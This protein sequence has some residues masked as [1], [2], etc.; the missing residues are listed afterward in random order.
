MRAEPAPEAR[1]DRPYLAPRESCKRFRYL[2]VPN[3]L[4]TEYLI[5]VL[6]PTRRSCGANTVASRN[7]T[8]RI[9]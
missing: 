2:E 8:G 5:P 4:R 1:L 3:D 9:A 6:T 7:A